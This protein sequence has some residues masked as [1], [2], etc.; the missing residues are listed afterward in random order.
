M[1][2][3]SLRVRPATD[4][5][6]P[7]LLAFGDELRERLLPDADG[8]RG[9]VQAL[10]AR[11]GPGGAL[12]ATRS[13]TPTATWWWSWTPRPR[14][15]GAAGHGAAHRRA[16]ERAARPAGG[17]HEP[18]RRPRPAPPPGG[19]PGPGGRGGRVRRG[20]R[21]RAARRVGPPRLARGQPLLRPA[22]LRPARGAARRA[23][24]GGA[25]APGGR[26]ARRPPSTWCG[27][28]AAQ[29]ACAGRWACRWARPCRRSS[30]GRLR[31]D[32]SVVP[33]A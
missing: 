10:P 30:E 1:A 15:G 11:V 28:A 25:P 24:G 33:P 2:R 16:R 26:R 8:G 17:A 27:C 20:A 29:C 9:R 19:R 5:D 13:T 23:R 6:L 7:A 3:P 31:P 18:R 21:R 14:P 22:G 12:R 32:R 4:A